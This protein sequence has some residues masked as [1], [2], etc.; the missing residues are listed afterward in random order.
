MR[1]D[2]Q[3]C[4]A[5]ECTG[6]SGFSA[7]EVKLRGVYVV[8]KVY[9]SE[10][11]FRFSVS[12]SENLNHPTTKYV[13]KIHKFPVHNLNIRILQHISNRLCRTHTQQLSIIYSNQIFV[14]CVCICACVLVLRTIA[15]RMR[16]GIEQ[17]IPSAVCRPGWRQLLPNR[18]S[19]QTRTRL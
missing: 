12:G 3:T 7:G 9:K 4:N 2:W 18:I 11:G 6:E 17:Q 19:Q 15:G 1:A 16:F 5:F 14:L 8:Y 10:R 13:H